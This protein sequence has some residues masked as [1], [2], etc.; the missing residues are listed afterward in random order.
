MIKF[1]GLTKRN[2]LVFFKNRQSVIF[3]LMTSI[4]VFC[5]YLLFLK[6]TYTDALD[7]VVASNEFLKTMVTSNDIDAY[8]NL[9]MLV[10]VLGSAMITVPF[11]CLT[12]AVRD[13]EFKVDYDIA[14]TPIKRWQIV[15]SYFVS[16][17]LSSIL[18][19]GIIL[20]AGLLILKLTGGLCITAKSVASAYGIVALGSVS[21]TAL[22]MVVV[23]MFKNTSALGAF[24]GILSAAAGFV[25]GAYIPVSQFSES[26]RTFCNIFP[27]SHITTLIR[28]ALLNDVLA[29]MDT[30]IGGYDNGLFV[31]SIKE[32]FSFKAFMFGKDLEI[33]HMLVYVCTWLAV[34]LILMI[35]VYTKTYKRR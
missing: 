26:I 23:L 29:K 33:R 2:L 8:A 34:S 12:T 3:S 28:N 35:F 9:V 5:L 25:I 24:F 18:M 20:T 6:G 4:I 31:G 21:G 19:T 16:A 32:L 14:A 30:Q 10:G 7:S 11:Y 13:R 15:L 22:F 17:A 27:A 1:F